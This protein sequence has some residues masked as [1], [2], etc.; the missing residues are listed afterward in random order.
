[1]AKNFYDVLEVSPRARLEVIKAAYRELIKKYHPDKAKGDETITKILIEAHDTLSDSDKRAA[2]DNEQRI[3]GSAKGGLGG[4]YQ[5]IELI[6]EGG[7]GETYKGKHILTKEPVC[8][9]HCSK[10]SPQ[11]EQVLIEE[12]KA[13]WDL[14]HF[15]IPA[16]RNLLKL[17]DGTLALVMSFIHGP[18]LEQVINKAGYLEPEHVAWITERILNVLRYMHYHGVVHGD[19]K[20]QNIIIQP[21]NHTGVLVD[22]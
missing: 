9:K 12:A 20:P 18:T 2:Y 5:E 11:H 14:R 10:I 17:K 16:I 15:S 21:E 7:F 22:F 8:I 3:K 6:A 4:E 1:M 13:M 19:I